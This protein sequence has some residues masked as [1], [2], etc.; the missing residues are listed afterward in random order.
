MSH[1]PPSPA[2]ASGENAAEYAITH[3]EPVAFSAIGS[4]FSHE[5]RDRLGVDRAAQLFPGITVQ[6][7]SR[8]HAVWAASQSRSDGGCARSACRSL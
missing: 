4:R 8:L 6:L 5:L 2:G 1:M 7:R 3:L